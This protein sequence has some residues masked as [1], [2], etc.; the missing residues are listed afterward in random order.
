MKQQT[1][2][3]KAIKRGHL[4]VNVPVMILM[5][6]IPSLGFY[7]SSIEIIPNWGIAVCFILGFAFA[8]LY[9][10]YKITKWRLWAFENVRNVHELKKRAIQDGLIWK[11]NKWYE[12]TEIQSD[13][14]KL[15]WKELERKFEK[16]DEYKE[17]FTIP[18]STTIFYSKLTNFVE[19][20]IM[21]GC[22]GFG[23]YLILDSD[24]YILG[25]VFSLI[26]GYF[27]FKEYRQATN[28]EPQITIDNKG[29]KTVNVEFKS[30]KEIKREELIYEIS[31]KRSKAYLSYNFKGGF[32]K[33]KIDDYDINPKEME[34]LLRTYRIRFKK[35]YS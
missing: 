22:F 6:G 4:I 21:L 10:S 33:I 31:G 25:G 20:T 8:W 15:K 29:I 2:V 19:M 24:D 5:I 35:N 23:I 12:R 14:D 18:L 30:W 26:G 13:S 28:T 1:T 16:E 32:E 34:N 9:W 11:D 17:D 7:L 27:A 3:E